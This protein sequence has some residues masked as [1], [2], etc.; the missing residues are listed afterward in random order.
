MRAA[1]PAAQARFIVRSAF[2]MRTTRLASGWNETHHK[3]STAHFPDDAEK[4]NRHFVEQATRCD[5]K[6]TI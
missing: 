2:E 5:K 1:I 4:T 6:A 3:A